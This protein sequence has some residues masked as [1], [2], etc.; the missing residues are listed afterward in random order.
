MAGR[1]EYVEMDGYLYC[2]RCGLPRKNRAHLLKPRLFA[3]RVA[4]PAPLFDADPTPHVP[5]VSL[6]GP[7][8]DED[9]AEDFARKQ[10]VSTRV[11]TTVI[12]LKEPA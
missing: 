2:A 4:A 10:R 8:A 11:A 7:F 6:Y 1:H 5:A 9:E 12:P 3:V